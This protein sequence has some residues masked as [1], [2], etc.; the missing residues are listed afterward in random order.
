MTIINPL[1]VNLVN[2]T[3]ADANA[4]DA[5]FNQ[6]VANVNANAANAGANSTITSLTGLVTPLSTNQGGTGA[7]TLPGFLYNLSGVMPP[8]LAT[9]KLLQV[10]SNT[11]AT[12]SFYPSVVSSTTAAQTI[13]TLNVSTLGANGLDTGTVAASQ[14]YYVYFCAGTSGTCL[15][16][17]T[18]AIQPSFTNLSGY[19]YAQRIGALITNSSGYLIPVIGDGRSMRYICPST[20]T[21]GLPQMA[22]GVVG[23]VSTPTW[24]A[25]SISGFVPATALKISLLAQNNSGTGAVVIVAPNPY[26]GTLNPSNGS[27]WESRNSSPSIVLGYQGPDAAMTVM[28]DLVLESS[29][30]YWATNSTVAS[31][32]CYG[33]EDNI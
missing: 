16:A 26:Y 33:W 8:I 15:V 20:G 28:G 29:Y 3:T 11:L 12:F 5:N 27:G 24:V 19:S 4:V 31:L 30:I 25:I 13:M 1:P 6:I 14:T 23:N 18:S 22:Y 32:N 21:Q 10:T 9:R 7:T 2:G 17:S